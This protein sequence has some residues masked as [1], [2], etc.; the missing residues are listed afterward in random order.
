MLMPKKVKY[1]KVQRGRRASGNAKGGAY[2]AFGDYGLQAQGRGWI[3]GAPDRGCPYR[4]HAC[5]QEAGKGLDPNLPRQA[6]HQAKP[7]E[8]RMGK[9]KGEIGVRGVAVVKPGTGP[10]RDRGRARRRSRVKTMRLA[11]GQ[12][13]D[14]DQVRDAPRCVASDPGGIDSQTLL[15]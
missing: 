14:Q 12:T 7:L 11:S 3:T 8:T 5:H 15:K 9:G 2:V 10:V 6:D 4:H 1:R 13:A